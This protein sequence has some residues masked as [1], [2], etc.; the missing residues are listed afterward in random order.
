MNKLRRYQL[1]LELYHRHKTE[2]IADA[3]VLRKYIYPV[4]PIS[5]TT[6]WTILTTPVNKELRELETQI[7]Q[8]QQLFS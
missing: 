8:Q 2:D 3:V 6:L 7:N 4:Y 1:I 5:R